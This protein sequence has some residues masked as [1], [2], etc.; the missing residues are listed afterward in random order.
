MRINGMA[1]ALVV[2]GSFAA[3]MHALAA[4]YCV[5]DGEGLQESLQA[6]GFNGSDDVIRLEAGVYDTASPDGFIYS[7]FLS[8]GGGDLD[9]SGGWNNNCTLRVSGQRSTIDGELQRPG[10]TIDNSST[11]TDVVR[12][13]YLQFIRGVASGSGQAGGLTVEDG[14]GFVEIDS[15]RFADNTSSHPTLGAAGGLRAS[16]VYSLY[17]RNNV[18]VSNDA[19]TAAVESAGAATLACNF[20]L[21]ADG[22]R[23][24]NNTVV[25]NTAGSG[26]ASD[27][28]G[29]RLDGDCPWEIANN[30]M[31]DNAGIDLELN[32]EG[33]TLRNNDIGER[34]GSEA[35]TTDSGNVSIDPQF[36]SATSVRPKRTSP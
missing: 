14:G 13:R 19:D 27:T 12:V 31:W 33:A 28:G 11:I 1:V 25:G 10:L 32:S 2:L 23:F 5:D 16:A 3:P 36:T 22:A 20:D 9:I 7:P 4:T 15:N 17:V 18:F 34:G 24:I 35:P 21:L 6:A 8:S 29:I 30:I 26:A